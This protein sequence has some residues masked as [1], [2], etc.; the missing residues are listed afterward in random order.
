[1]TS[2]RQEFIEKVR[3]STAKKMEAASE[4]LLKAREAG[5]GPVFSEDQQA[6]LS[7]LCKQKNVD[8]AEF[9]AAY[10]TYVISGFL[11]TATGPELV[12]FVEKAVTNCPEPAEIIGLYRKKSGRQPSGEKPADK[13]ERMFQALRAEREKAKNA[14]QYNEQLVKTNEGSLNMAWQLYTSQLKRAAAVL[15]WTPEMQQEAWDKGNGLMTSRAC[16]SMLI[17]R[18]N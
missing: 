13:L 2:P 9:L 18:R 15:N 1:M 4:A 7:A 14:S 11:P 12:A 16:M 17:R 6:K 10:T 5:E 3:R 8:P